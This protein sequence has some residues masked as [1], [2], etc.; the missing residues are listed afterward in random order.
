L[1]ERWLP[2][3]IGLTVS[4]LADSGAGSLRAAILT[5]DAGKQ[6]D[7]FTIDFSVAGTID[8]QGPLP[9]LNNAIALQGPGA[10]SLRIQRD[11]AVTFTSAIV[12]VDAGQTAS[13][14][15]LTIADGTAGGI[16]N[17]GTLSVNGCALI[18]NST[19]FGGGIFSAGTLSVTN[20]TLSGN[21]A[22]G[23]GGILCFGAT[24]IS[25][26]LLSGN[27]ATTNGGGINNDGPL[28]VRDSSFTCNSATD[29]GGIFTGFTLTA[30]GCTFTGNAATSV[31][32]PGDV[33]VGGEGGGICVVDGLAKL[34]G[35]TFSSNSAGVTGG[36]I[37]SDGFVTLAEATLTGNSATEGGAIFNAGGLTVSGSSLSDNIASDSGGG[38][39]NRATA[40]VQDSTLSGNSAGSAGGGLFN[41]ASGPLTV[42]DSVVCSNV[43]PFGADLYNLGV[44]TL[45]DSTVGVVGP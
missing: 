21:S 25:R 41:G 28:T 35:S 23:G 33:V 6:S 32:L 40:T 36:G 17:R 24:T 22:V 44:A 11:S 5:A 13:L 4:S 29:G 19:L 10:S 34:S 31:I 14:S 38:I 9:D 26:C 1:E 37:F 27:T 42:A 18:A 12:T 16:S 3:Q 7:K 15:S 45:N 39:Y 2:A 8:L 43:A 20:S 30:S